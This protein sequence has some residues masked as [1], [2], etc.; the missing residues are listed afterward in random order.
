[1]TSCSDAPYAICV[2]VGPNPLELER[3][4]D[5]VKSI[6]A[7]EPHRSTM[8][9]ID[10][11]VEPRDLDKVVSAPASMQ[12]V[13]I[14]LRRD[15]RPDFKSK[16]ISA[17]VLTGL[18]WIQK[19]TEAKFAI[20]LDTDSLVIGPFRQKIC[21]K[22]GED[23]SLAMIGA[24]SRTPNGTLRDWSVHRK[25]IRDL[26]GLLPIRQP[27]R[28]AAYYADPVRRHIR[29]LYA[30][31]RAHAYQDGEHCLG[32]GYAL[33][34]EFLDRMAAAGYL[35][36]PQLWICVD[37]PEDV[38]VGM[39]VRAVGMRFADQVEPGDVFGVRYRG[40]PYPPEELLNRRYAII[41]AVKNDDAHSEAEIRAYF[42]EKRDAADPAR[43]S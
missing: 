1:M 30:R 42:S 3:L 20:R 2:P 18:A 32:G 29:R 41:H 26:T 24:Y 14:H 6:A 16:G 17:A 36:D 25:P 4:K 33:S 28:V 5:L 7:F 35:D 27:W 39:H 21:E 34:R 11:H 22:L 31:A 13:S 43:L 38:A 37:I 15:I 10:D 23:G 40:L 19:N 12:L 9:M 8:V